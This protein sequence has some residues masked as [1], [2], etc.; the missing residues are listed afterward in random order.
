[1]NIDMIKALIKCSIRDISIKKESVLSMNSSCGS[2]ID[3]DGGS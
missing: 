2:S 1:M 3:E